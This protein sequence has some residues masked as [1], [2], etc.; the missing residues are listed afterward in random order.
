MTAHLLDDLIARLEAATEGSRELD[1]RIHAALHPNQRVMFDSGS[2]RPAREATYGPLSNFGL[3]GWE[4]W[5][6]LAR[7]FDA[8]QV[9]T[10]LD[11][12]LTLVPEDA[13]LRE[14]GQWWDISKPGGWFCTV[15]RWERDG[16][17]RLVERPYTHGIPDD[18]GNVMPPTAPTPALAVTIAALKARWAMEMQR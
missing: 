9:T 13:R 11:A 2:I 3:D 14:L 12:A 1:V 16:D 17:L 15:L 10:S 6:A 7:L 4:D 5:E 8:P 18:D